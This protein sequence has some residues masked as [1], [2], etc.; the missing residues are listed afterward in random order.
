MLGTGG[1]FIIGGVAA[2]GIGAVGI[3]GVAIAA[4]GAAASTAA[5]RDAVGSPDDIGGRGAV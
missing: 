4:R 5:L 1:A 2:R 3:D